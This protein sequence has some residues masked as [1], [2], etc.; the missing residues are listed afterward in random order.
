L[1]FFVESP[2]SLYYESDGFQALSGLIA[3]EGAL[4]GLRLK[5]RLVPQRLTLIKD[6]VKSMAQAQ[7]VLEGLAVKT[8]GL[9][10]E[11]RGEASLAG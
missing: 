10:A 2:Q 6:N 5:Q 7:D 8:E 1:L 3:S 11:I 4:R 9:V